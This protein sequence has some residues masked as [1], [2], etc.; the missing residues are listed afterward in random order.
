MISHVDQSPVLD[1]DITLEF[2]CLVVCNCLACGLRKVQQSHDGTFCNVNTH[3]QVE[4]QSKFWSAAAGEV[5]TSNKPNRMQSKKHQINSL[6]F[7]VCRHHSPRP[8]A[9][10]T[11]S[12]PSQAKQMEAD[13]LNRKAAGSK[14]KA[15]TYGRY[16]W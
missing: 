4:V 6:A 14:T 3:V 9:R 5:V 1:V 15:Q 16:G 12:V 11:P 7:Q 13:L 2:T 10:L 8:S